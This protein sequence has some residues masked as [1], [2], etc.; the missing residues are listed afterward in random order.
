[1]MSLPANRC[2]G[3]MPMVK[4]SSMA[5]LGLDKVKTTV[6]ASGAVIDLMSS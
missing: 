4:L 3:R 1:M 5:A 2:L 6:W